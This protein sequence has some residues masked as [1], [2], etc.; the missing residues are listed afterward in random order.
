MKFL[1]AGTRVR[2]PHGTGTGTHP[3][4][5]PVRSGVPLKRVDQDI[6]LVPPSQITVI[7]EPGGGESE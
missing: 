2:T 6:T 4:A 3:N 1:P 7:E 5:I